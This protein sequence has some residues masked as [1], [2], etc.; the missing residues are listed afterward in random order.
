VEGGNVHRP[1]LIGRGVPAGSAVLLV[2]LFALCGGASATSSPPRHAFPVT[3]KAANGKVTIRHRPRRIVS[4]SPTATEDLFAIGAGRQVVAVDE[5][6]DYPKQT[7]RTKLSPYTPNVE[8]IAGYRPDLVVVATDANNVVRALGKLHVPV[9]LDPATTNLAGA[10]TQ[11][12][13]LGAATGHRRAAGAL[14]TKIRKRIAS[15][16]ASVPKK[17]L[18]VYHELSP[19]HYSATSS[20]FIGS[21]YRLF[22]L[23]NIADRADSSGSPYPQLSDE[24]IISANP[25]L[26]VLADTTCCGQNA[27]TVKARPGWSSITAVQRGAIVP[28]DDSIA[29]R[30]GP[31]ITRFVAAIARALRST[32]S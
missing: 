30:W 13:Q 25:D 19:S 14:V 17:N 5:F 32:P 28:V 16:V 4:L 15:L 6:S 10:Y 11:I 18:S 29:A 12:R 9:L 7:P 22:K 8:A 23:K 31:R 1:A 21:I 2:L 3:V 24:Y 20:T 27:G 26:I